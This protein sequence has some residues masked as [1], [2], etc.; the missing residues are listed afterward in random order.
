ML[1]ESISYKE[2]DYA[3]NN[4]RLNKSSGIYNIPNEIPSNDN[5]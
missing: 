2:V 1:N 4:L 5:I 3:I